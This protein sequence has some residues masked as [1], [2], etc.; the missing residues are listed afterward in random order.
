MPANQAADIVI[1]GDQHI[2]KDV[3]VLAG[4]EAS[5]SGPTPRT[6]WLPP[7]WGFYKDVHLFGAA[8]FQL[9]SISTRDH[10]YTGVGYIQ[11]FDTSGTAASF[12]LRR[13]K[14]GRY[15]VAFRV[16]NGES[17]AVKTM[18]VYVNGIFACRLRIKPTGSWNQWSE[19][20]KYLNLVAGNNVITVR[21][22]ENDS[23]GIHLNGL[24]IPYQPTLGS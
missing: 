9:P 11:G 14:A 22:D 15:R 18:S 17:G 7:T 16:A 1:T 2:S 5:L 19:V 10:G 13:G 8:K 4:S 23:G 21:R 24:L 3:E 20:S 12:Y 6:N